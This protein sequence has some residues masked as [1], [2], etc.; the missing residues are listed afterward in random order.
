MV[1]LVWM[2]DLS[3]RKENARER[4]LLIHLLTTKKYVYAVTAYGIELL[5]QDPIILLKTK[6]RGTT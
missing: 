6:E 4:D 3:K 5:L 2:L 1:T